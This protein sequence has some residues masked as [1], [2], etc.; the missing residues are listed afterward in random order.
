MITTAA[1]SAPFAQALALTVQLASVAIYLLFS[2][3]VTLH[4]GLVETTD[5]SMMP[6][7]LPLFRSIS[8]YTIPRQARFKWPPTEW[9]STAY[10]VH[11]IFISIF[12]RFCA[13]VTVPMPIMIQICRWRTPSSVL[14]FSH[15]GRI[16]TYPPRHGKASMLDQAVRHRIDKWFSSTISAISRHQRIIPTSMSYFLKADRTLFSSTISK[17]MIWVLAALWVSKVLSHVKR[18]VETRSILFFSFEQDSIDLVFLSSKQLHQT[19]HASALH[20]PR[21]HL[22]RQLKN[23]W[24]GTMDSVFFVFS[25]I[26]ANL[27]NITESKQ[28]YLYFICKL[29]I[30]YH[31]ESVDISRFDYS[32]VL[33]NKINR[34]NRGPRPNI[35]RCWYKHRSFTCNNTRSFFSFSKECSRAERI[36]AV[37][38]FSSRVNTT[39]TLTNKNILH[40]RRSAME[41]DQKAS[42][43]TMRCFFLQTWILLL[44][45]PTVWPLLFVFAKLKVIFFL[46][47][48]TACAKDVFRFFHGFHLLNTSL[49]TVKMANG[50]PSSCIRSSHS[51]GCC[52][53]QP[54]GGLWRERKALGFAIFLFFFQSS[55]L[56]VFV[57]KQVSDS[58][59][60]HTN[61]VFW[62][63]V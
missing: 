61:N 26:K 3:A 21:W 52:S 51:F 46:R 53:E 20:Y 35:I 55:V 38:F 4:C 62:F 1:H 50:L 33:F 60:N 24:N 56:R 37:L 48:T 17:S 9:E 36:R 18:P 40:D 5:P 41:N 44:A 25:S 43:E 59:C 58:I 23:D 39:R 8:C 31:F 19:Q 10:V 42:D 49:S 29:H 15:A 45:G 54:Y 34:L 32:M 7:S 27:K 22:R 63:L 16:F 12:R 2:W 28:P 13:S 11:G 30:Q 6:C 57:Q 47:K 14:L